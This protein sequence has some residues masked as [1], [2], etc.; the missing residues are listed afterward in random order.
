M[1]VVRVRM[2]QDEQRFALFG[3][4]LSN[5]VG[6]GAWDWGIRSLGQRDQETHLFL[7][8]QKMTII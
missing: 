7:L 1:S 2:Q 8:R 4:F 5:Q 3:F 6:I